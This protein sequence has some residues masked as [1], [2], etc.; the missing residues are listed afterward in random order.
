MF[1]FQ[2]NTT[3]FPIF[4]MENHHYRDREDENHMYHTPQFVF[5]ILVIA[6]QYCFI[7]PV[8][9]DL[10][11]DPGRWLQISV[12]FHMMYGAYIDLSL[13]I[14]EAS[15]VVHAQIRIKVIKMTRLLAFEIL[16]GLR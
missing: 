13:P 14:L 9:K 6:S 8:L 12:A 11:K 10:R 1:K 5:A 3:G 16:S 2:L 7:T 15:T 4:D